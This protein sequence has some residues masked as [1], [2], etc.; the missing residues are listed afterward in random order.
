MKGEGDAPIAEGDDTGSA[1]G[2]TPHYVPRLIKSA[3]NDIDVLVSLVFWFF[4]RIIAIR[5]H[6]ASSAAP[7]NPSM[8]TTVTH[9]QIR[10]PPALHEKLA[11]W[12]GEDKKSLNAL[13]IGILERAVERR[14]KPG[15]GS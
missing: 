1:S 6:L 9:F 5:H 7:S 4:A 2:P 8:P 3:Q 15:D 10:M 14:D 12:A 13:V 11:S